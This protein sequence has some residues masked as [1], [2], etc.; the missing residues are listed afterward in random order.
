MA[1]IEK[2]GRHKAIMEII[3]KTGWSYE[4]ANSEL[5]KAEER[6]K[7]TPK[8]YILYRFYELS[9]HEQDEVFTIAASREIRK[10]Y[11]KKSVTSLFLNKEK[12][13]KFFSKYVKRPWCVNTKI[14]LQDF[15]EI[16]SDTDRIIYKPIS[17]HR[18]DDIESFDI[19]K[20]NIKS[21]YELLLSYPKGVVEQYV[22]QHTKMASLNPESVNTVRIVTLSSNETPVLPDGR[23]L[24]IAYAGVRMG[25]TPGAIVDNL[26]SGGMMAGVDIHT[27]IIVT[28]AADRAGNVFSVHPVTGTVIKGFEIPLFNEAIAMVKEAIVEMKIEGYIGWDIAIRE[29]GPVLIECNTSPGS[30]GLST[31]YAHEHKGMKPLMEKYLWMRNRLNETTSYKKFAADIDRC[32]DINKIKEL[33]ESSNLVFLRN[34]FWKQREI[35]F[36]TKNEI[37]K[38]KAMIK[39]QWLQH[40]FE[41]IIPLNKNIGRFR[42]PAGLYGIFI[43]SRAKVGDGCVI[44]PHV[45]IG[46][47]TLPDSKGAGFPIV[48]NNVYI[49]V[50]AKIIGN[51]TIGDSV[52]VGANC[53]VTED[54]PSNSVVVLEKSK[55]IQKTDAVKNEFLTPAKFL[56]KKYGSII[57]DF[58]EDKAKTNLRVGLATVGNI[59]EIISLYKERVNWLPWKG[60]S[61]WRNYF[62]SHSRDSFLKL[63]RNKEY[64]V[65]KCG[66]E[67]I[68]GFCVNSDNESWE[69][70][71][72]DS[73][74]LSRVVTKN[75]Y[76][77]IGRLIADYAKQLTR[78]ANKQSLR[79]ECLYSNKKLNDIWK[80]YGFVFV[81]DVE[82]KS[83]FS[84]REWK[85]QE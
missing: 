62:K 16:F 58:N 11:D 49:G 19:S 50:G 54:V 33:R 70:T 67:I 32:S 81:K 83:H 51:V 71:G 52:R 30:D 31:P 18:G 26:H 13:N 84:L 22:V 78:D 17:G 37:E 59:D 12:T 65:L 42:A 9:E 28:D 56:E 14:S 61:Q 45:T 21:V 75:G 2:Q 72:K 24:D 82:G 34:E 25:R 76:R 3:E 46:A 85:C 5:S 43:S 4:R 29:D 23:M 7:C 69:D 57:Y 38:E 73:Y 68:G 8:E 44:F 74:Y 36:T 10:E 55:I 39:Y 64:Y 20:E 6:T 41:C 80:K 40:F 15:K 77:G 60:H 53:C 48:G 63:I 27:G 66:E 1:Q 47:N 35:V 79:L